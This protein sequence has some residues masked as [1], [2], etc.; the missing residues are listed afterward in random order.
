MANQKPGLRERKYGY[1]KNKKIPAMHI[2]LPAG[3]ALA[4]ISGLVKVIVFNPDGSYKWI[5]GLILGACLVPAWVCLIWLAVADRSTLPGALPNPDD[6]IE[7]SWADKAARDAL[8]VV[9]GVCGAPTFILE[10]FF[11]DQVSVI[12]E[13][14]VGVIILGCVSYAIS[15]FIRRCRA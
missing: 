8:G 7:K 10:V 2:A 13:V 15:Y 11:E 5:G 1:T 6:S 4:L 12:P 14:L 9:L 3:V